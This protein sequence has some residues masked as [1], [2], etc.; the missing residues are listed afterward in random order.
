MDTTLGF[1]FFDDHLPGLNQFILELVEAYTARKINSWDDLKE[2]VNIFFTHARMDE[3]ESLVPGWRKMASCSEGVTLTHVMCV[4]LGLY[5]LPEFQKLSREQQQIAK[6]FVLFHDI[7]KFHIRGKKD[8]MHAFRSAVVTANLL[9]RFGFPITPKYHEL[10]LSWSEYTYHAFITNDGDTAPRPDNQKLPEVLAGIDQLYGKNTPATLII[11][12]ALLHI[13]LNVDVLYPTPAPL[14]ENE[15]KRY[16]DPILF[17]LLKVMMLADNEG[18]SLFD[19]EASARQRKDT[20]K[21][22]E[23]VEGLI[24]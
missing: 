19:S 11:K 15:T 23:R 22:F 9:P 18:W 20:L 13:S 12:T 2:R 7:D 16:I 1:P 5:M 14:T 8:T 10:V 17:P 6:W 21:V 4:F 3:M 24:S